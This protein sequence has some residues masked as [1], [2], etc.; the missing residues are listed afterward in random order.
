M[1]RSQEAR[2]GRPVGPVFIDVD[3]EHGA[4]VLTSSSDRAGLE[5]EIEPLGDPH[6]RTHVYVLP[7]STGA[8]VVH[9]A[10][11]ASLPAGSYTIL[12]V[13]GE[14]CG[15]VDVTPGRATSAEWL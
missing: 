10:V 7:R 2:P 12:D 14:P 9:A 4:L 6:R 8:S 1:S 5:V 13:H 11:F 15:E 3:D